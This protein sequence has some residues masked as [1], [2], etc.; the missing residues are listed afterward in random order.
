[1]YWFR[2]PVSS[3]RADVESIGLSDVLK[4]LG[5]VGEGME[6]ELLFD[7]ATW[8]VWSA[9]LVGVLAA[10]L[11]RRR[12]PVIEDTRI[13]RHDMPARITH[14]THGIGTMMLLISGIALG[15]FFT[16]TLVGGGEPVW[17]WMNVHF[18]FVTMF[19]FGTFYYG[20]NTLISPKRFGEHLPTKNAVD[21]T[22]RH[23][24][25]LL[26]FKKF[27]F[28]PEAKYFESEKMAYL[29]AFASTVLIIIT[30]LLKVAAHAIDMPAWI[31][32]VATPVHDIST[33]AMLA[34]FVAHVFF[35]A[36]IPVSWPVLRSMF[37][38]YV[39]REYAEKDHAG[40]IAKI[41]GRPVTD[42]AK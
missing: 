33:V 41:E 14:W 35:A 8:L 23:Y 34:F 38:G 40:W 6:R 5:G 36:V 19:L 22:K 31:L 24:G 18:V 29:M 13:L 2:E 9:P 15:L 26:G 11:S 4:S 39:S 25:L 37:S 7:S 16:P 21:Y 17:T 32:A 1:M 42:D 12:D 30:G 20:A 3:N 28:P 10:G 27:T